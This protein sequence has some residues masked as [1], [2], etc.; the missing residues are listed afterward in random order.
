MFAN[1]ECH[2]FFHIIG[3]DIYVLFEF[4]YHCTIKQLC[5][6]KYPYPPT[7]G[8]EKSGGG[9]SKAQAF[10]ERREG[11][12]QYIFFHPFSIFIQLYVKFR[13]L[14]FASRVKNE[15]TSKDKGKRIRSTPVLNSAKIIIIITI[16]PIKCKLMSDQLATPD[17]A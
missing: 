11:L 14:H 8:I 12:P 15:K 6:R 16:S 9:V 3:N 10:P 7:K 2:I 17:G 1:H 5:S 13:R 4:T